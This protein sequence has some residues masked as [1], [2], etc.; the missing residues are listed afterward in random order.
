MAVDGASPRARA[1]AVRKRRPSSNASMPDGTELNQYRAALSGSTARIRP[2]GRVTRASSASAIGTSR[3]C[4]RTATQNVQ[5]NAPSTNGRWAASEAANPARALIPRT[6]SRA[7]RTRST[8]R[9][10]PNRRSWEICS[11]AKLISAV[12]TPHPTSRI[13]LPGRG[14][15]ACSRNSANESFH[16]RSRTC[17][18]VSDVRASRPRTMSAKRDCTTESEARLAV[19]GSPAFAVAR[20]GATG[21][22][23]LASAGWLLR[24]TAIRDPRSEEEL[25]AG[26]WELETGN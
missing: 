1:T 9:S 3:T 4:C 8:S 7:S 14:F 25:K 21:C 11:R 23:R 26:N 15:S 13:R 18:S 17:L 19:R 6:R 2:P 5:S 16:Q 20:Y 10:T 22:W 12:P 24:G